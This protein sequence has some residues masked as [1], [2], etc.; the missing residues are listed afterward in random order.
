MAER[1]SNFKLDNFSSFWDYEMTI[2]ERPMQEEILR[3]HIK[4]WKSLN[5]KQRKIILGFLNSR[6]AKDAKSAFLKELKILGQRI[7][8]DQMKGRI[9]N[10]NCLLI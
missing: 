4:N 8:H 7:A 9:Q 6:R 5:L 10:G 1:A 2:G 3:A